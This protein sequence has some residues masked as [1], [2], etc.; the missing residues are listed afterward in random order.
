MTSRHSATAPDAPT[1]TAVRPWARY[2]PE[3][4][5]SRTGRRTR[6]S[7]TRKTVSIVGGVFAWVVATV[8][9]ALIV[10]LVVVPRVVGGEPYTILTGSMTPL[11]P[12]GTVVVTKPVPFSEVRV[13]DV[14]TYQIK[15]GEPAVVTHR[16][17]AVDLA[18]GTTTLRTQG[19][20]NSAADQETVQEKQVRGV[21]WYWIPAVGYL[22]AI[23][24]GGGREQL[25]QLIGVALIGYAVWMLIVA[26]RR[27]AASTKQGEAA[28]STDRSGAPASRHENAS[29]SGP[30]QKVSVPPES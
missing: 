18:D 5:H 15:S 3:H 13:G 4:K 2:P 21:V 20:A 25:A 16:V 30:A 8:M 7:A 23:G 24:T 10:L 11:M 1:A 19:D 29:D 27:R 28:R 9:I 17:T 14:V 12:P 22:T 6:V 26:L